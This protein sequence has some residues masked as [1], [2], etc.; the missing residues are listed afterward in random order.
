METDFLGIVKQVHKS[1]T[2][3]CGPITANGASKERTDGL[4]WTC[5]CACSVVLTLEG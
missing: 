2:G 1:D 4:H 5:A 3:C